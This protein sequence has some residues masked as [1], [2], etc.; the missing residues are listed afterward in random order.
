[1]TCLEIA[2]RIGYCNQED[3]TRLLSEADEIAAMITGFAKTL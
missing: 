2:L 3:H 1:M